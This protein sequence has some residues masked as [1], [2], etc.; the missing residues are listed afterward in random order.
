MP[1]R[2]HPTN[3]KPRSLLYKIGI[4]FFNRLAYERTYLLLVYP[5]GPAGHHEQRV[6]GMLPFEY[7]GFYYLLHLTSNSLSRLFSGTCR[8]R[9]LNNPRGKSTA[10]QNIL[11]FLSTAT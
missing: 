11:N 10:L 6:V 9:Q 2:W 7:Q 8:V 4:R 1:K 3:H 5:V